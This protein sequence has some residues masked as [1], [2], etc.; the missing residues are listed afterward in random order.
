M[1]LVG[2]GNCCAYHYRQ[3]TLSKIIE[4]DTLKYLSKSQFDTRFRT[5][6]MAAL[7]MYPEM[8]YQIREVRLLEGDKILMMTD[9]LYAYLSEE[10]ILHHLNRKAPDAQERLNSLLK[11]SN[12][13]G[14]TDNITAMILEF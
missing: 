10:E 4:E 7:G 5:S 9:G 1:V 6:P 13:H 8:G 2:V 11:L 3:G 14:N 12:S